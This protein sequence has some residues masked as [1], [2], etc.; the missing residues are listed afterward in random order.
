MH[1]RC[2]ILAVYMMANGYMNNQHMSIYNLTYI[3]T[4]IHTYR[5][6]QAARSLLRK[7]STLVQYIV[8]IPNFMQL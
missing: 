1:I 3:H 6:N 8:V 2:E 7:K 4:Y 5:S